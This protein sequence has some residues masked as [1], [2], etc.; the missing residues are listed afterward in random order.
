MPQKH[1]VAL[2]PVQ[3]T[4]LIPLY[5]RAVETRKNRSVLRDPKALEMVDAIDYDFAKFDGGPSLLGS[6]LRTAIFATHFPNSAL[7]FE[8]A[9]SWIVANQDR[10]DAMK[11]VHARMKWACD[12]PRELEQSGLNLRLLETRTLAQLPRELR[13]PLRHRLMLPVLGALLRKRFG[14]YK[15]NLFRTL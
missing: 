14:T 6:V 5:G 7:A 12:D 15:V 9:G 10:H 11:K 1:R 13:A 2:G 3:E 4:L 8:T